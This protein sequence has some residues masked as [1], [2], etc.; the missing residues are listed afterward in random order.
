LND[1]PEQSFVVQYFINTT[2]FDDGGFSITVNAIDEVDNFDSKY[3][4]FVIDSVSPIVVLSSPLNNSL[5]KG[6]VPLNFS[7]IE[8]NPF[9]FVYSLN[10]GNEEPLD[11][12][13]DIDTSDWMDMRYV[14]EVNVTDDADNFN[15]S[16]YNIT[17][18]S[19]EPVIT[20]IF[21]SN[22][23]FIQA[24]TEIAFE[25]LEA[26]LAFA[27]YSVNDGQPQDLSSISII[28]TS[29][30]PDGTYDIEVFAEDSVGHNTSLNFA[31]TVDNSPPRVVSTSP[32]KDDE[33]IPVD[34]S[35]R[36]QFNE[37]MNRLSVMEAV[38]I[39]PSINFTTAWSLDNLTLIIIP[40]TNLTNTTTYTVVIN[41]SAEDMAGNALA[42]D[43]VLSFTTTIA[44]KEDLLWLV[45]LSVLA[46]IVGLI[47]L[48]WLIATRKKETSEEEDE[49][50]VEEKEALDEEDVDAGLLEEEALGEEAAVKAEG[51]NT[52]VTI[53][54]EEGLTGDDI[55]ELK[56][57]IALS[58]ERTAEEALEE[59]LDLEED[60][61]EGGDEPEGEEEI[62]S[63]EDEFEDEVEPD[64][65]EELE[66][67]ELGGED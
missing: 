40:D 50:D 48:A 37:L 19:S 16:W 56:G 12:S 45:I 18:D 51:K 6:G 1:E 7:V 41:T 36:I 21:P 25:I 10:H 8:D 43:F 28:D 20:L 60:E 26:N 53:G 54:L 31:F 58:Q 30:W 59:E 42:E 47:L 22:N 62:E 27:N 23:S 5:I 13:Y 11:P 24:G 38:S 57:A 4:E 64:R 35:I 65:E 66:E 15:L 52:L 14:V 34:I 55:E 46:L 67:G 39:S 61:L 17:I 44:Q 49:F 29:G 63:E 2:L 33:V 3:Y 32:S 9:A